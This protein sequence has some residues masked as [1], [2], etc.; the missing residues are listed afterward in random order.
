[1]DGSSVAAMVRPVSQTDSVQVL[2]FV[3]GEAENT[4]YAKEGQRRHTRQ[5]LSGSGIFRALF[6]YRAWIERVYSC[7]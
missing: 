7:N 2:K 3:A 6:I 5:H 1:M 4:G